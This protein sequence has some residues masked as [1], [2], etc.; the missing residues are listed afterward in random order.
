MSSC[1]Q[2]RS[3]TLSCLHRLMDDLEEKGVSWIALY[4][5]DIHRVRP[6][7]TQAVFFSRYSFNLHTSSSQRPLAFLPSTS[8]PLPNRTQRHRPLPLLS[9]QSD[10][11]AK[12][13]FLLPSL[14]A[15]TTTHLLRTLSSSPRSRATALLSLSS[16][17]FA[18]FFFFLAWT[19]SFASFLLCGP[20]TLCTTSQSSYSFLHCIPT[21][22][23][24]SPPPLYRRVL[25]KKVWRRERHS[26]F[27]RDLCHLLSNGHDASNSS[28]SNAASPPRPLPLTPAPTKRHIFHLISSSALLI[29]RFEQQCLQRRACT[30]DSVGTSR[31]FLQAGRERGGA[32][33]PSGA[34][35]QGGRGA[36][37]G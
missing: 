11:E 2:L 22:P 8:P 27:R 35:A 29:S 19:A 30:A 15:T 32:Q 6:E 13:R 12:T 14:K 21:S 24:A 5:A 9:L 26:R 1:Q 3:R 25:V 31:V 33:V 10:A 37:G 36:E 17:D 16:F 7:L 34:H 4:S 20:L 28:L 18:P 23:M